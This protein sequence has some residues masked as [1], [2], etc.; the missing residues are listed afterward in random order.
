MIK[1]INVNVHGEGVVYDSNNSTGETI[2]KKIY[3]WFKCHIRK[4]KKYFLKCNGYE[5]AEWNTKNDGSGESYIPGSSFEY[6][7]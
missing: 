5:I 4:L 6:E 1:T 3:Y 7:K 2:Y